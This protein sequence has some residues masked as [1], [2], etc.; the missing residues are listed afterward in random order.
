MISILSIVEESARLLRAA[1]PRD[2][3]VECRCADPP[4]IMADPTQVQQVLLNL[5]TNAAQAM[6]GLSGN[7]EIRCEN[8]TLDATSARPDLNLR[9]GRYARVVVSDTG[10]GMNAAT[11]RRIFEPF[12]TTKPV[13]KGTGLGLSV[14]Y[15]IM[16]GHEG[17]IVAH[18]EP[19]KGSTFELYFPLT[20]AVTYALGTTEEAKATGEGRGQ[21]ILYIDDDEAQL[22]LLKRLMERWGYRVSAYH[23]QRVA[24]DLLLAGEPR[25]DLVVT[26]FTMPGMSGL[27]VARA[28]R[29]A[30]QDL[31]VIV[32]SGYITDE[33]RAQAAAA[34]VRE[35]ISKPLD[36][37]LLRDVM[38]RQLMPPKAPN[39]QET[40]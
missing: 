18:S 36:L 35:L 7:V 21:Y 40:I 29:E 4:A 2:V 23:E 3:R 1:L 39:R 30:R 14:A 17:A 37:E 33:L 8:V 26:D 34:G 12:F 16:Q 32:V 11:Q 28:I 38:Q 10:H 6:E 22:F 31:P 20:H 24:L 25:F 15:S 13:G 19:G 5:G 9:P 27:E